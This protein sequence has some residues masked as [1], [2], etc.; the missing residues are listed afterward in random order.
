L[1]DDEAAGPQDG[2][3]DWSIG[4]GDRKEGGTDAE[5]QG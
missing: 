3:A 4:S 5:F 2:A 1:F